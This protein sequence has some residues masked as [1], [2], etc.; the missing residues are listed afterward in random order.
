MLS[1]HINSKGWETMS[2]CIF[3]LNK[4]RPSKLNFKPPILQIL[5]FIIS[6]RYCHHRSDNDIIIPIDVGPRKWEG[7][8]LASAQQDFY[9]DPSIILEFFCQLF[10]SLAFTSLAFISLLISN[11]FV[12]IFVKIYACFIMVS[13]LPLI[14]YLKKKNNIVNIT[15]MQVQFCTN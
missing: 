7:V 8:L 12:Q 10:T 1:R 2:K 15:L 6:Y 13:M 9:S 4:N 11:I 3:S 14:T 5:G